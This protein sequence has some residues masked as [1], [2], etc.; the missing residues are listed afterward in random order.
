LETTYEGPKIV[1][2]A[3]LQMLVSQFEG[4]KML[5]DRA[6]NEFYTKISDLRNFMVSLRK[7]ILDAKRIKKILR[8]LPER[9]RIKVTILE[10][11]KDLDAMKIEE[12]VGTLQ[13]FEFSLPPVKKVKSITLKVAKEKSKVSSDED[14]DEDEGITM[15]AK[16]FRKLMK[17]Q[18]FKN[19]YSKKLK[20]D[21]KGAEQ[22]EV[23]KK[24]PRGPRCYECSSYSHM[25]ED[26]GNL[27]QEKEKSLSATLSDDSEEKETPG[28]DQKFLAFIAPYVDPVKF[29]SYYSKSSDEEEQKEAYK[30]LYVKFMKL[31]E[32]NQKNV[33][34]LNSMKTERSTLLQKIT[35]F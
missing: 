22:D 8:S 1:K 31:R 23:D 30:I 34:E 18:K 13:T 6:F 5:E 4:M 14:I 21:P 3:K 33:L 19:K 20:N 17:N 16:N 24:D 9:Y 10:E 2:S 28:K 7:K 29:Q 12:L 11:S 32:T 27:K 35:D 25:R 15:L 26:C